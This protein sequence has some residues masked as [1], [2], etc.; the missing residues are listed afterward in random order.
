MAFVWTSSQHLSATQQIVKTVRY[1][2]CLARLHMTSRS[3]FA[4]RASAQALRGLI[5]HR[6][7]SGCLQISA[8]D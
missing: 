8:S 6:Q 3:I 7:S 1:V 4:M 5:V 2:P